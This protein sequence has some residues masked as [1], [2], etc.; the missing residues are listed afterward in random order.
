MSDSPLVIVSAD[1]HAGPPNMAGYR[2]YMDPD[3]KAEFDQ[4]VEGTEAYEAAGDAAGSHGGA[5]S[6]PGEEGLWDIAER[7]RYLDAD[8]IS[9]E[10][11]FTQGGLPF[12]PYPAIAQG[13]RKPLNFVGSPE[14]VAAGCRAY[15]RWLAD[16]CSRD[17][18][19]HLGVARIPIPDV[20]ASV[21]VLEEA[22]QSG[23]RGGVYL[24]PLV[25][26]FQPRYNDPIYESLWAACEANSVTI[27]L[28]GGARRYYGGG[29]E[30]TALVLAETDWFSRR[31]VWFMIF[32]GVFE[33]FPKLHLAV[34]EQR[35]HWVGP[36]LRELDSISDWPGARKVWERIRR[37][38]SEYFRSNCF[39]G[40]SFM[41]RL[42]CE[43]RADTGVHQMMW[44]SDYPH[45]EGTWPWTDTAL[46][47]TFGCGVTSDELRA[48]LGGNAARCYHLDWS[49]LERT[50]KRVGPMESALRIPVSKLPDHSGD[51]A[52]PSWAFRRKGVFA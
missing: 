41:S 10:I 35:T 51:G 29:P 11:I 7:E 39:I 46:R 40:A 26:D 42:E 30:S 19:R 28:H 2:E 50:A 32:S 48:M 5:K 24:P 1:C 21:K 17:F 34:T 13:G 38:P 18:D 44:G 43:A 31:A 25:D 9:A 45:V 22:L 36:L 33:R 27:N 8:G 49:A 4:Y 12:G 14:Q 16:L 52:V 20:A 6:R 15:N 37:K 47:W 23:L 3:H